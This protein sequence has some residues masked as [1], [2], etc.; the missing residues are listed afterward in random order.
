MDLSKNKGFLRQEAVN[1]IPHTEKREKVLL[2]EMPESSGSFLCPFQ[3][4]QFCHG[5]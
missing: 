2:S 4:F 3:S 1:Y 5:N